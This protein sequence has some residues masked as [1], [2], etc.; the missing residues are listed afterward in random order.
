MVRRTRGRP[1]VRAL[2]G[3]LGLLTGLLAGPAELRAQT[4]RSAGAQADP[5]VGLRAGWLDAEQ[6]AS[7]LELLSSLAKP[8]GFFNPQNPGDS[9]F[10]NTDLAFRGDYAFVGNYNGFN[11]YD[12]SDPAEPRLRASVICPGGQGDISVYGDLLFLSVQEVRSRLDC[13]AQ[14]TG[15][16]VDPERFRGI[17]IFN[18]SDV[19]NPL[20]V[21]AVQTCRGSHTHTLVTDPNDDTN[22]YVYVSGTSPVRPPAEL[23]GC[24]DVQSP[25]DPNTSY[26]SIAVVQVPLNSPQE[27]RVVNE[28]RVFGDPE[29][30]EI[31]A[32]WP[33]GDHG[34]GTQTTRATNM[35][36][37]IT[38]YPEIGLAAGACSGNGLL[39]D[40]SDPVHPVRIDE[41]TDPN[42]AYWHSATFNNDGSAVVFTDEWG[43]GRGARCQAGDPPEWGANAIF[44][45]VDQRLV[46]ASYYKLPAAQDSTENCVAHNGSLVPVPG[47]DIKVQA[48]YQ[49]GVS[50]FDFTDPASPVEIAFH[51]RGPVHPN[52]M[53]MAGSW[54]VYALASEY[55]A[56]H[57]KRGWVCALKRSNLTVFAA[58][59]SFWVRCSLGTSSR[60]SSPRAIS[61]LMISPLYQYAD[62]LP[63]GGRR[64]GPAAVDARRGRRRARPHRDLLPVPANRPAQR[65]RRMGG[66]RGRGGQR[67]RHQPPARRHPGV[68]PRDHRGDRDDAPTAAQG[69][70]GSDRPTSTRGLQLSLLP[71]ERQGGGDLS[72]V[73]ALES[74]GVELVGARL[75]VT[76]VPIFSHGRSAVRRASGDLVHAKLALEAVR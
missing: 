35:C 18:I 4:D 65:R 30:G 44:R 38:A 56:G 42:F 75:A 37:D 11:V 45:I 60:M 49:G 3:T 15:E 21:A 27:A 70:V 20:Q 43:G 64:A 74:R 24:S 7:N 66:R 73:S 53:V 46:F 10:A 57:T 52:Q 29:T 76:V 47:R 58:S 14:G 61:E 19:D 2:L 8:E 6:A 71:A 9:R 36:H 26:W 59:I 54:S 63:P 28:P 39:F 5:R 72:D 51:D 48:W 12:I 40:I 31:A 25:E 34:E 68:Q 23:D 55:V 13:G 33:G 41:V 17:R 32:L 50:V 69:R 1:W 67:H 22:L 16:P 62:Q